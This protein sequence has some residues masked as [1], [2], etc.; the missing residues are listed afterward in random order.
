MNWLRQGYA[1]ARDIAGY[2]AEGGHSPAGVP[3]V[4]GHRSESRHLN[5]ESSC[6]D[7]Q[8]MMG[9]T[10]KLGNTDGMSINELCHYLLFP[11][12]RNIVWKSSIIIYRCLEGWMDG[13]RILN[14]LSKLA[15]NLWYMGSHCLAKSVWV[16]SSIIGTSSMSCFPRIGTGQGSQLA[17][18]KRRF[19]FC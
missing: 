15:F 1:L 8:R 18:L 9:I 10:M 13:C 17:L 6:G 3:F 7:P 2:R 19:C 5:C 16:T 12:L 4:G 14:T 11:G